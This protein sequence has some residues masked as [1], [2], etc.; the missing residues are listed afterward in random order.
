MFKS[1]RHSFIRMNMLVISLI[2][3]VAFAVVCVITYTNVYQKINQELNMLLTWSGE[4]PNDAPPPQREEP[5][6]QQREEENPFDDV[7]R[8][9]FVVDV[10]KEGTYELTQNRM[11]LNPAEF[12]IAGMLAVVEKRGNEQG[13]FTTDEH[14]WAYRVQTQEDGR[15]TVAFVE[16]SE[17]KQL[18]TSLTTVFLAVAAVLLVVIW[19]VSRW[20]AGRSVAPIEE[21]YNNQRRFVQDAS[22]ELKTPVAVMRT[23]LELLESHPEE[24]VASQRD[25]IDNMMAE[26]KH[27]EHLTSGLL[28]LARADADDGKKAGTV[29]SFSDTVQ[30]CILSLEAVLYE[31]DLH[32]E[33]EVEESIHILGHRED[34]RRLV[35]ILLEN[36]I[37]YTPQSGEMTLSLASSQKK[38]VL[39]VCNTGAGI[40]SEDLP[41]VFE[42]FYR[43]DAARVREENSYGLGLSIAKGIVQKNAGS[44]TVSSEEGGLTRFTVAFPLM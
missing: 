27:M 2:M 5:A 39:Q 30:D 6:G 16:T 19:F 36:A 11:F 37:Q 31:K 26:T 32:F 1:L 23:N 17:V 9:A 3:L 24:T 28:E 13:R 35:R 25:W 40:S 22:H 20:F 42:R 29:F 14:S 15:Q 4:R 21:A 33:A 38:A 7:P 44:I 18:L 12:D 41:H 43:G 10:T 34:I 8:I